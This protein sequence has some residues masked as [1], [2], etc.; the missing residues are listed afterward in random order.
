[1]QLLVLRRVVVSARARGMP[2]ITT[3]GKLFSIK[4]VGGWSV[5][6]R[7]D[8]D[9]RANHATPFQSSGNN[10]AQIRAGGPNIW[11]RSMYARFR[12]RGTDSSPSGATMAVRPEGK[13]RINR[14]SDV[15]PVTRLRTE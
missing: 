7:R 1:M 10:R 3:R 6:G 15:I 13:R 9:V 11:S 5:T 12:W 14:P 2:E 4:I 8:F